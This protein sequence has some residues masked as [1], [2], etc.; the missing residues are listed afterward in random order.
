MKSNTFKTLTASGQ[1]LAG[2][3]VVEGVFVNTNS[4]GTM[5]L[6]HGTAAADTGNPISAATITLGTAPVY[7][8][9]GNLHCTAGC[10]AAFGGTVDVTFHI[11]ESIN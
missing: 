9:L 1:V 3:G 7:Y 2:E 8:Y 5:I 4:S 10:Y 11:Q 6:Y